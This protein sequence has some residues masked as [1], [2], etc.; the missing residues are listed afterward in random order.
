MFSN[1]LPKVTG[2]FHSMGIA[3]WSNKSKPF[4]EAAE[5]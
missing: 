3:H 4:T 5:K 2:T 1:I